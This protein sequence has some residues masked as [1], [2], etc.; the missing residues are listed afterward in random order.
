MQ[1]VVM[2]A[3][4]PVGMVVLT[5]KGSRLRAAIDPEAR[6]MC[7][8]ALVSRR[9]ARPPT[10]VR[11]VPTIEVLQIVFDLS[12][13]LFLESWHRTALS[14]MNNEL[15]VLSNRRPQVQLYASLVVRCLS[16]LRRRPPKGF[17]LGVDIAG[18]VKA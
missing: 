15:P 5:E 6:S 4:L 10:A 8:A 14:R 12:R 3:F 17:D 2:A 1:L 16:A 18:G 11:C 9:P 13:I 7:L